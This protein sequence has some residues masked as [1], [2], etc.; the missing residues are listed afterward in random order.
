MSFKLVPAFVSVAI[1]SFIFIIWQENSSFSA[2]NDFKTNPESI[3]QAKPIWNNNQDSIP[4]TFLIAAV[5]DLMLGTNFPSPKFLPPEGYENLLLSPLKYFQNADF[6]FGNLEGT[7][8][9]SGGI[10]KKCKDSN[11][12]Y[13]F[14]MNNLSATVFKNAGFDVMNMA[15][16]HSGDFGLVGRQNTVRVL[17]END[18]ESCGLLT[19]PAC[20]VDRKGRKI[21][22]VG[23]SP[24]NGTNDINDSARV[25]AL[26][27]SLKPLC[28][29]LIVTFH[30]GAEGRTKQHISRKHE[31]FYGE[32]RGNVYQFARLA[33]D[34]GADVILGHG[35]HVP[36][37]VDLY[38]GKF[39]AY[40]MGNFCTYARFSLKG[41]NAYAPLFNI[42][43]DKQGNLIKAQVLSYFQVG[44]GI[45]K[46]DSLNRAF[47]TIKLLTKTDI[48]EAPLA[49]GKNG[50]IF[51]KTI[52]FK[53]K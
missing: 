4:D 14:R 13:L 43:V 48:P 39:I 9:D 25:V 16:N 49:F 42:Y 20:I 17:Q 34:A 19:K 44:E 7:I 45:P 35:P 22:V 12:C 6:T 10:A 27:D 33:I 15:N 32:D 29:L 46:P 38:K 23:F 50:F 30:G 53:A 8:L 41:E 3:F 40:S 51:P 37:A 52:K 1:F 28:D 47:K 26:V 2:A 5:G 18:I 36:R 11:V 31:F 21:G 24:N